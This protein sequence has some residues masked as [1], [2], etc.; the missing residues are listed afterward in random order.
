MTYGNASC[1]KLHKPP[2]PKPT[3]KTFLSSSVCL[4]P[5]A[6]IC[7]PTDMYK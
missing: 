7:T 1:K 5:P 4:A 3:T 2:P 6:A